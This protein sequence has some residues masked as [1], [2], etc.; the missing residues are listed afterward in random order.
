LKNIIKDNNKEIEDNDIALDKERRKLDDRDLKKKQQATT[1][2]LRQEC[3]KVNIDISIAESRIK[4]LEG[5]KE[6]TML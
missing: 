3:N 1:T 2:A 4:D 6:M 5:L